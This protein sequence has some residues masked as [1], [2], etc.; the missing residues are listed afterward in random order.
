V[1]LLEL[2][3]TAGDSPRSAGAGRPQAAASASQ[4]EG[5]LARGR[6]RI[7]QAFD[8][9][10]RTIDT[11]ARLL[12][13]DSAD[14]IEESLLRREPWSAL[15][16]RLV[17]ANERFERKVGSVV[18][19]VADDLQQQIA[20]DLAELKAA[21]AADAIMREFRQRANFDRLVERV[22]AWRPDPEAA[23]SAMAWEPNIRTDR[24]IAV[25][26]GAILG[27]ALGEIPIIAKGFSTVIGRVIL[28]APVLARC[29]LP[30]SGSIVLAVIGAAAGGVVAGARH[31]RN[32]DSRQ[33]EL[34]S[35]VEGAIE[36]AVRIVRRSFAEEHNRV[37]QDF[38][39]A[40][41]QNAPQPASAPAADP[42]ADWRW[43]VS[44]IVSELGAT[45]S[46]Q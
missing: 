9:I 35:E 45:R 24:I 30:I 41:A 42:I 1:R 44:K 6:K 26:L 31:R 33:R 15:E 20:D 3:D 32:A 27:G 4:H 18:E 25:G 13:H 2:L 36:A 12:F 40:F 22:S 14:A 17:E 19:Q 29:L 16:T 5:I 11:E 28:T 23:E 7:D 39:R 43:R 8:E 38:Q 21:T 46:S 37:Q 34:S 10:G